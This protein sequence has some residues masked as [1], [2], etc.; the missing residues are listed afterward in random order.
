MLFKSEISTSSFLT[1]VN[2]EI[3]EVVMSCSLIL[4]SSMSIVS[5][6]RNLAV[7]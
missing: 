4:S 6:Y 5:V 7:F 3:N 1:E 2:S